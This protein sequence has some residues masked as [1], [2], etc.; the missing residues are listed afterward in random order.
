MIKYSSRK[1]HSK[2]QNLWETEGRGKSSN[3]YSKNEAVRGGEFPVN[4]S[5]HT[6][7]KKRS[8]K[9]IQAGHLMITQLRVGSFRVKDRIRP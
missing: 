8:S 2:R 6:N 7:L 3:P 5:Q 4:A 9:T 1:V